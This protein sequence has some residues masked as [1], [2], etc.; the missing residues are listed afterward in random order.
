ML[1]TSINFAAIFW[2]RLQN[3][4]ATIHHHHHN[5]SLQLWI[6][7]QCN[8]TSIIH[9][10]LYTIQVKSTSCLCTVLRKKSP[11]CCSRKCLTERQLIV[12][13]VLLQ[14]KTFLQ[15]PYYCRRIHSAI[16]VRACYSIVPILPNDS[17]HWK[18][19]THEDHTLIYNSLCTL[20]QWVLIYAIIM[21]IGGWIISKNS[22][23]ADYETLSAILKK[24]RKFIPKCNV[25]L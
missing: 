16:T 10:I 8:S 7:P 13:E 22:D 17:L 24:F 9:Q 2:V 6:H 21:L 12:I 11:S 15:I 1:A 20:K 23:Y 4:L 18:I 5:F 19:F 3:L 25:Q 14:G